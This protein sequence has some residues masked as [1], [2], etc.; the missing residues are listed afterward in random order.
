MGWPC[1][2]PDVTIWKRSH[3]WTHCHQ[4][5]QNNEYILADKGTP[6]HLFSW[7]FAHINLGYPS[8]PYILRPFTKPEIH[9]EPAPEQRCRRQFNRRIS[10]IQI[11]VEHAFGILKGRFPA[12]EDLGTTENIQDVYQTVQALF[13]LHNVCI[14]LQDW[15]EEAP[16]FPAFEP[17]PD[18]DKDGDLLGDL[19]EYGGP[20]VDAQVEVPGWETDEWLKE[21][22][23]RRHEVILDDLFPVAEWILATIFIKYRQI[24]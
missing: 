18:D 22:G 8:L 21:E 3:L 6:S 1:S 20:A 12:L 5:L 24:L 16:L 9:R 17:E 19:G 15:P 2:V 11:Y 7:C 14:D 23:L 10:S 13:V 4:F